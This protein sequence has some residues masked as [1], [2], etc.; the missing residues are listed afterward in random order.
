MDKFDI[1][2]EMVLMCVSDRDTS[3]DTVRHYALRSKVVLD[4]RPQS[5]WV[6]I[7]NVGLARTQPF[8]KKVAFICQELYW[9]PQCDGFEY[10][11]CAE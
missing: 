6:R 2:R 1:R 11:H 3:S 4:L 10:P 9:S 8:D 7:D 5:K